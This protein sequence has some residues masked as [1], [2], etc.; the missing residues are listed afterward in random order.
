MSFKSKRLVRVKLVTW[1]PKNPELK[2]ERSY[3]TTW[4]DYCNRMQYKTYCETYEMD[5]PKLQDKFFGAPLFKLKKLVNR[6]PWNKM[7]RLIEFISW[8]ISTIKLG[9]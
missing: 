3:L 2:I 1:N 6:F 5:K 7:I 8:L 4:E 9:Q